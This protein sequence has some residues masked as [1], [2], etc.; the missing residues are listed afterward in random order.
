MVLSCRAIWATDTTTRFLGLLVCKSNVEEWF[1]GLLHWFARTMWR[2]R[3]LGK[4]Q[5]ATRVEP[6]ILVVVQ[7]RMLGHRQAGKARAVRVQRGADS[8]GN[9]ATGHPRH[10]DKV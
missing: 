3:V 5:R 2:S 8:T 1:L 7:T 9:W 10:S 4:T 6:A